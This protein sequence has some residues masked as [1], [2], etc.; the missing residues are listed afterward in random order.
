MS[1]NMVSDIWTHNLSFV[2]RFNN[3]FTGMAIR[4]ELPVRLDSTFI[5]PVSRNDGAGIR[6]SDGTYRF[7]DLPAGTHRVRWLPALT[8]GYR[9]WVSF[10]NG[11]EVTTPTANPNSVIEKD[12]WPSP[13]SKLSPASTS[14]RGKLKGNNI[15]DLE[16]RIMPVTIG[17]TSYFTR[18][19]QLGEFLYPLSMPVKPES[20]GLLK[21]QIEIDGGGRTVNSGEFIPPGSGS[22]FS[23]A[24]FKVRSGMCSRIVFQVT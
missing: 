14:I 24:E 23:A 10:D 3:H 22:A 5:R 7:I 20:N 11:L 12:L 18:S 19:D 15:S 2:V 21:L 4:D 9:G 13:K 8:D 1:S 17:A 16:V 6:Q